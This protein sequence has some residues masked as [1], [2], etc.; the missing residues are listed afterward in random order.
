MAGGEVLDGVDEDGTA[1]VLDLD[2][3]EVGVDHDD[4]E[5][6]VGVG[7]CVAD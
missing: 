5:P 3:V 1:C 2:G 7:D 6:I 4:A